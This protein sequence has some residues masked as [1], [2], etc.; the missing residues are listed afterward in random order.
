MQTAFVVIVP[1]AESCVADLRTQYDA[2]AALGMPA[3]ITILFPFMAFESIS[4]DVL[5]RAQE[6][7]G[8][9]RPFS[10][11]LR[12]TKRFPE[13]L[14]LA[15]EPSEPFAALP[16][17]LE[18]AFPDYPAYGGAFGDAIPHLTVAQGSRDV[19]DD[20]ETVLHERLRQP[21]H[22]QVDHVSLFAQTDEGWEQKHDFNL[23]VAA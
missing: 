2:S 5:E 14:W 23:K 12:T 15:P 17:A 18:S 7:L 11:E 21:I 20:A 9:H 3:H 6:I 8:R 13:F 10:F 22:A 16:R 1:A 19:L 4:D